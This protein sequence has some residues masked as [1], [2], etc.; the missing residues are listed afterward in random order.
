V[1]LRQGGLRKRDVTHES[2]RFS[3]PLDVAARRGHT[4]VAERLLAFAGISPLGRG[5][6]APP[7]P[8]QSRR[9]GSARP[10]STTAL[11][12]R[13]QLMWPPHHASRS[14]AH[15]ASGH[16]TPRSASP[17]SRGAAKPGTPRAAS[18]GSKLPVTPRESLHEAVQRARSCASERGHSAGSRERRR[19]PAVQLAAMRRLCERPVFSMPESK[20]TGGLYDRER[21]APHLQTP[22]PPR[23]P[24]AAG[25]A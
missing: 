2:V 14:S 12:S 1:L 18:P 25:G 3:T 5:R 6:Q 23:L 20:P 17:L 7:P 15:V 4:A 8:P 11:S 19:S 24:G 10:P 16:S 9:P 22:R 13:D 21:S